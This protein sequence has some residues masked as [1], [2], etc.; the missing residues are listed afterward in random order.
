MSPEQ[1]KDSESDNACITRAPCWN[2]VSVALPALAIT[3]G[4]LVLIA[5]PS[6]RGDFGGAMGSG[7]LFILGVCA[8]CVLGATAA[9]IALVREER[10]PWLTVIGLVGN[11]AVLVPVLGLFLRG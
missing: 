4:L 11:S 2:I 9:M 8:A 6:G 10:M 5:N 7:I 3:V 1:L